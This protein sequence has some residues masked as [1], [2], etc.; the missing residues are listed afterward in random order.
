MIKQILFLF[1]KDEK[2][3]FFIL[4]LLIML[5]N[6]VDILGIA[7]VVPFVAILTNPEIL[8]S[9]SDFSYYINQFKF[10]FE[11]NT[12]FEF[13]FLTGCIFLFLLTFSIVF[14]SIVVFLQI[15]FS[16]MREHSICE[17][18][19]MHYVR[20]N[21]KWFLNRNSA[22]LTKNILSETGQIIFNS[23]FGIINLISQIFLILLILT[24]LFIVNPKVTMIL[25]FI[26][27][28]SYGLIIYLIKKNKKNFS[29]ERLE[30]NKNRF[31][32]LSEL[33]QLIKLVKINSKEYFFTNRFSKASLKYA[34]NITFAQSAGVLPRYLIELV[35]FGGA[36][37]F[38]L[39]SI[40]NLGNF[41]ELI[42]SITLF[43]F[44]GYKLLPSMQ[45]AYQS[46]IQ[47]K[48][49]SSGLKNLYEELKN[50]NTDDF[51][52]NLDEFKF[53]K[54]LKLENISF[55]YT[56]LGDLILKNINIQIPA[57]SKVGILGESGSG[58]STLIDIILGLLNLSNGELIIDGVVIS[59]KNKKK[60]QSKIGYVPQQV[61][62]LDASIA[63]NIAFGIDISKID[64]EKVE[65]VSRIANLHDFVKQKLSKG[66][67]TIVGENGARISGGQKQRIAI[68]RSLY[69]DP[70]VIIFDEAT[71][72]LD[73]FNERVV[74]DAINNLRRKITIISI[75]HK[76]STV[77]NY[78]LIY[79]L[80]KGKIE[81][82]GTYGDIQK[83]YHEKNK[84]FK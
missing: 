83:I 12:H 68:A 32:A 57:F 60:W 75:T 64:M 31:L 46:T 16:Y 8:N 10:F 78:D 55:Q 76:L 29:D 72:S 73:P 5:M 36:I 3:N 49:T 20:Q 51:L 11:I 34:T 13:V 21:Y 14:K 23:I 69:H 53:E 33:F 62:L 22:D 59:E 74:L 35:A 52:Q 77:K 84:K 38:I 15:K 30:E 81:L 26:F 41:Y 47:I 2:K 6:I 65:E 42:P 28:F 48:H 9:N 50:N 27:A 45:Q 43:I 25:L 17:R 58:K 19:T 67:D 66:Y 54:Y 70:S 80:E 56:E 24:L 82:K 44:A 18:L 7:S 37:I 40:K 61:Q 71:S 39:I 1:S 4:L 63:E 79:L